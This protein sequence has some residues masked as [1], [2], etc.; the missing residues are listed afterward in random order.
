MIVDA[1]QYTDYTI[2]ANRTFEWNG[3]QT[4]AEQDK[5]QH[6][7]YAKIVQELKPDIAINPTN[8]RIP[9][10]LLEVYQHTGTRIIEIAPTEGISTTKLIRKIRREEES[11]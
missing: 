10:V 6:E 1:M 4:L 8:H 9:D 5:L 7:R 2:V 11:L 3:K